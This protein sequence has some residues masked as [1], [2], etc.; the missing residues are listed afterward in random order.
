MSS[1]FDNDFVDYIVDTFTFGKASS[2]KARKE[3]EEAGAEYDAAMKDIAKNTKSAKELYSEGKEVAGA[4]A[5]NKAGIAKRNA[6]AAA[7]QGSGSK[8]MSA[9]QGAQG[10]VDASTQ[11]F[12]EGASNAAALAQSQQALQNQLAAQGAEAKYKSKVA[13]AQERADQANRRVASNASTAA[14]IGST[15]L[16]GLSGE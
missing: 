3:I 13:A 11:G 12:D 15:F 5:G 4:Q 16:K 14:T 1:I 7:M 10:A 6:K 8:L 9:I 2:N